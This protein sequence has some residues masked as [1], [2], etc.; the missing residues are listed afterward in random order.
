MTSTCCGLR[1]ASST[2]GSLPPLKARAGSPG[3]APGPR[4]G[5]GRMPGRR[6]TTDAPTTTSRD[7]AKRLGKGAI[8]LLALGAPFVAA[9]PATAQG[10]DTPEPSNTHGYAQASVDAS[11]AAAPQS[12]AAGPPGGAAAGE[13]GGNAAPQSGVAA[14]ETSGDAE[15]SL[16]GSADANT[17][18]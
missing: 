13:P 3:S 4:K 10:D 15:A 1:R 2:A 6:L 5:A 11:A 17:A 12:S 8:A 9:A 7:D 14:A 16:N 18:H